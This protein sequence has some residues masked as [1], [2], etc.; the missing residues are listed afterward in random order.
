MFLPTEKV[1]VFRNYGVNQPAIVMLKK[2]IVCYSVA[3][4]EEEKKCTVE[5]PCLLF[6]VCFFKN[7]FVIDIIFV[8]LS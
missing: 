7:S 4:S 5:L 3:L 2:V 6:F 1:V 8:F